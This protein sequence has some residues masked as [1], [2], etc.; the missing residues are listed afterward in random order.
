MFR[1]YIFWALAL[2]FVV[3]LG[4]SLRQKNYAT[5]PHPGET[6]DEY[7]FA[8]AGLSLIENGVPTSWTG[9]DAVTRAG[10][11]AAVPY[12][13]IGYQRINVD[14]IFDLQP[15]RPDFSI[16]TPWFDKPPGFALLIGAYSY[17]KGARQF[18]QTGVG[19]IRRPMFTI[20]MITT[21]LIFILAS[22]FYN[23]WVGLLSALF[24]SVVP[25][26]VISSRLAMAENGYIPL[27]LGAII[28]IDIYLKRRRSLYLLSAAALAALAIFFKMSGI[29]V[30]LSLLLIL[31]LYHPKKGKKEALI[32]TFLVGISGLVAF[33]IY[34][35]LINWKV[36]LDVF[37][38]QSNLFYGAGA[39]I[40]FSVLTRNS[41]AKFFTDGWIL[42]AWV[43]TF[44]IIFNGWRKERGTTILGISLFSY[45]VIFL[46]FGSEAYGW[47]R[48]P[49]FPFII[50]FLA[51]LTERLFVKP[52][53]ILIFTL[54]LIP[55]GVSMH[56]LLGIEG[57]QSFVYPLR[58][59]I[60]L[61]LG[62]FALDFWISKRLVLPKRIFFVL[63]LIVNIIFAIKE[64]LYFNVDNWFFVT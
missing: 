5:V 3:C 16:V 51:R 21:V 34:G 29:S 48:F 47:Y 13:E 20:G 40:I 56:K 50:I 14:S 42:L 39:D 35:F 18:I 17:L 37:V 44:L 52:N 15:A 11:S 22:R 6:T 57:F 1:K 58:I 36:F 32:K 7:G 46:I 28:L 41:I 19:I 2:L 62:V 33:F 59:L 9:V 61:V 4:N 26:T 23:K 30:L 25:T 43:S 12:R 24:Y 55:L 60:A 64:I 53:L 54:F 10:G 63:L 49:F 31:L 45:L 8:W 38:A 27:F